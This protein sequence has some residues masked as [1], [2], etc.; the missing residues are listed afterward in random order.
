MPLASVSTKAKPSY[1]A[2]DRMPLLFPFLDLEAE[3]ASMWDEVL[4][5]V[6]GVFRRQQFIM[7]PEVAELEKQ[8][9]TLVGSQFAI[10]CASGT[11]ALQLAL[12]ASHVGAGDEVIT[13]PF[14]FV[15]TASSI[16]RLQAKPVF[17]DIDPDTYTLDWRQIE[18]AI[19]PYTKAIIPV[20]LFGLPADMSPIVEIARDHGLAVIEDAAQAIGARY[21]ER[22]VGG[23][24]SCGC[25]SFFPSKN[26][27]GAGDGGM[28]TTNDPHL[29]EQASI[30]RNHGSRT[31]YSYEQ[32]GIN[33]R[34]DTLQ[35]AVLLVKLRYL[36]KFTAAR[37]RNAERY[38]EL[39]RCAGLQKWLRWPEENSTKLH[40]YH[41]FVIEIEERDRLRD[42]LR[43][44]GIPSEVYYPLPLHLQAAFSD[45]RYLPAAFPQAERV[46]NH[47]LALP[48]SPRITAEQQERVVEHIT[49][50]FASHS[51][52][53]SS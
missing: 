20:H 6:E 12:M 47:V 15:A 21:G 23:I 42:H 35:A 29:A 10:A 4:A 51:A 40:V 27:G 25:F 49:S 37:R 17:V 26:L 36:D 32:L 13:T 14:T 41:Q 24:G 34:L 50:F 33:S 52:S 46:S 19:T 38:R 31:R 22:P 7:G 11:D 45:L 3:F 28:L 44:S 9:A 2:Q 5:A 43:R 48:I 18:A 53:S 16:A 39:F 30:L 1:L 8:I